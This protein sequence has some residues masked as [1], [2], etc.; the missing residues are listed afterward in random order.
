MADLNEHRHYVGATELV[1]SCHIERA[2]HLLHS[3]A[4]QRL[5]ERRSDHELERHHSERDRPRALHILLVCIERHHRL[6]RRVH[7][8]IV[9]LVLR[10]HQ[11]EQYAH[12]VVYCRSD[13]CN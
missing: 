3:G 9:E 13:Y 11:S 10:V 1:R 4:Q 12:A 2:D 7:R 8:A 6:R 5:V